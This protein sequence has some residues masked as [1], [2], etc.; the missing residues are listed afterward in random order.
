MRIRSLLFLAAVPF[1]SRAAAQQQ[2]DIRRAAIPNVS[3]RLGG[4]FS[5]LRIVAWQHD[6]IALTGVVGAGTRVDG[7]SLN[8]SNPATGMKYFVDAADDAN[9][10]ANRLELRVPRGARV[11]AKA[12][13]ATIVAMGVTGGLDLNIIGGSVQVGGQPR[14][15]VIESM[16][17]SVTFTGHADYARIKT[18]TGNIVFNGGGDDVS[19]TTVSG[20]ITV[21]SGDRPATRIRLESVTGPLAYVGGFARGGDAR[22]DTHAGAVD[23]HVPRGAAMS[24]DAVTMTGTI[25]NGWSKAR[26]IAGREGRGMELG[27][28]S[29]MGGAS[30][31]VRSFKGNV[32]LLPD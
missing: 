2:V 16:D 3:V 6:S 30:V 22:F 7:G 24:V 12:G 8:G 20:V 32:R 23:L 25:E 4:E 29:G 21:A 17:G 5:S 26:P 18:A 10:A 11:W 19:L 31:S 14:E 13:S 28:S 1:A 9:A 27:F 15:L